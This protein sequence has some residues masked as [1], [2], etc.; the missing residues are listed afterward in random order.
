M[1]NL[2]DLREGWEKNEKEGKGG[3][4]KAFRWENHREKDMS[5]ESGRVQRMFLS[6]SLFPIHVEEERK[7][8]SHWTTK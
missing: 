4:K 1:M 7:R 5:S 2:K 6:L 8:K 3:K